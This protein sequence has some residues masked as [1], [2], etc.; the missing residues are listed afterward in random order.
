MSR[1]DIRSTLPE[2][3]YLSVMVAMQADPAEA[4]KASHESSEHGRPWAAAQR[5]PCQTKGMGRQRS[6]PALAWGPTPKEP[7]GLQRL[8]DGRFDGGNR[9]MGVDAAVGIENTL[10]PGLPQLQR[11]ID[12]GES[13]SGFSTK[14][15]HQVD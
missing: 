9:F 12:G 14:T 4:Q 7:F 11:Q 8:S 15:V 13:R 5:F 3:G 6:Q 10:L 1:M 2:L